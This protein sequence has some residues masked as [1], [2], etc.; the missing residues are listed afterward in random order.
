MELIKKEVRIRSADL[1]F[2]GTKARL[3]FV[4]YRKNIVGGKQIHWGLSCSRYATFQESTS[5][6]ENTIHFHMHIDYFISNI[7]RNEKNQ[8]RI[9]HRRTSKCSGGIHS[10]QLKNGISA[11]QFCW[12][13]VLVFSF[14]VIEPNSS[15]FLWFL[16]FYFKILNR[17]LFFV[18]C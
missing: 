13:F 16:Q 12:C 8:W 7:L 2:F 3:L 14:N 1:Y 17:L 11:L 5:S 9:S 10:F 15:S 18:S 6:T 4:I